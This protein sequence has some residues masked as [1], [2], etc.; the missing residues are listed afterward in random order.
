[1]TAALMRILAR[2][3]AVVGPDRTHR[4]R[5][6]QAVAGAYKRDINPRSHSH[7]RPARAFELVSPVLASLGLRD[8][9]TVGYRRFVGTT[10]RTIVLT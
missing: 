9:V 4:V 1:M 3:T 8:M 6:Q 10:M 2:L 7:E 5:L